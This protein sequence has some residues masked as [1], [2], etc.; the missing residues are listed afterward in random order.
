MD[1]ILNFGWRTAGL[2]PLAAARPSA[3]MLWARGGVGLKPSASARPRAHKFQ[4]DVFCGTSEIDI[5]FQTGQLVH[6]IFNKILS[7]T[8]MFIKQITKNSKKSSRQS[9]LS[10]GDGE[11]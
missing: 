6:K 2:K 3:P 11:G 4:K 5:I 1:G 10:V 7:R 9:D 8:L